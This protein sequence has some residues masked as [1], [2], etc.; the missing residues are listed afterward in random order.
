MEEWKIFTGSGKESLKENPLEDLPDPPPWRDFS[1]WNKK[2]GKILKLEEHEIRMINAAL[3]LRRSLLVTGP[4]GCG[5]SSIAYAV[6][7]ELRLGD[8]LW[9]PINSRSTVREG[10]YEYDAVARLRD[11]NLEQQ[12][13][14]H[15]SWLKQ[16]EESSQ[17]DTDIKHKELLINELDPNDIGR[18]MKLGPLGTA[19]FPDTQPKVLLIDEIDKADIDL[20]NDL[21]HVLEEGVYKIPEL[22]PIARHRKTVNVL[23]R[24]GGLNTKKKGIVQCDAF[25]FIVLSSNGERD[26]PPAFLRRCLQLNLKLPD[27]EKL[28]EIVLAYLDTMSSKEMDQLIK[29]FIKK[30]DSSKLATDQLLNAAFMIIKGEIPNLDECEK[31]GNEL[32]QDLDG[33]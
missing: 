30:S 10:L 20:P 31:I 21:L 14:S 32:F 7:M 23:N 4:P 18:Y 12:L 22:T 28:Q 9:W 26:L 15:I 5:K 8:V 3:F 17:A 19:L 13:M 24:F 25:P 27:E 2:R 16:E 6:A 33:L 11:A 1:T 29:Q